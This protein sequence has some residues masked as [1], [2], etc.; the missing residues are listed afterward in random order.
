MDSN[1]IDQDKL[2]IM[3]NRLMEMA[4][5]RRY[6]FITLLSPVSMLTILDLVYTYNFDF[7]RE[8]VLSK[9]DN[10]IKQ[11][12]NKNSTITYNKLLIEAIKVH[13]N[14]RSPLVR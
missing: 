6:A 11:R 2:K 5:T 14:S 4:E 13:Y 9:F 10:L 1:L 8:L 12:R 7:D 3:F